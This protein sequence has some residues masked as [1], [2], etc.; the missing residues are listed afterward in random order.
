MKF[1]GEVHVMEVTQMMERGARQ[2]VL[3]HE[4]KNYSILKK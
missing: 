4:K 1:S 3:S 2:E